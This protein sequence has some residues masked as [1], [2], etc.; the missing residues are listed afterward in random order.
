MA[1]A[2]PVLHT[3]RLVLRRPVERDAQG[4]FRVAR[5]PEV[6]RYYGVEPFATHDQALR[7]VDW[8]NRI[9]AESTGIRWIITLRGQDEYIGD[10]GYSK[11][12]AEHSRAEL[13][14]KLAQAHWRRGIMAEALT[15]VLDHGFQAL[16]LNRV[17][18]LVDPRNEASFK[19]LQR[20][21]FDA[22]GVLREYEYEKE[23]FIDLVMMS[24][25]RRQWNGAGGA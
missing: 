6:M 19:L 12:V 21:G 20:L 2:F 18:A 22:E 7:E 14:Y 16:E 17:E 5:D 1:A 24:L 10:A 8:C 15:Q 13:G 9:Y 4:L 11:Y 23:A 3:E 25:L